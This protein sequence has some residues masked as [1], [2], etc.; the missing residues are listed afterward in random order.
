[1]TEKIIR[2]LAQCIDE[3]TGDVLE[4][5]IMSTE[6]LQ[7]AT[8]LQDLGYTHIK[9]IDFLQKI[10]DFKISHQI[11]LNII[12]RCPTCA[13]KTVKAGTFKSKF[14]AVLTDHTV[15]IQRTQCK[16]GWYGKCSLDGM[17]GNNIHPDLLQK[18]ALQGSKESYQKSSQS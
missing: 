18:Q 2:F 1:M 16:C 7:K 11:M 10:Q 8:T 5:S 15:T 4:E 9:Q 17:F 14:H 13:S 6:V 12:D 3:K